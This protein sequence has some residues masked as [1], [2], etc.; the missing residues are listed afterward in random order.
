MIEIYKPLYCKKHSLMLKKFRPTRLG[1]PIAGSLIVAIALAFVIHPAWLL[2]LGATALYV[3]FAC[4]AISLDLDDKL[5]MI[6]ELAFLRRKRIE[7]HLPLNIRGVVE[8]RQALK[9]DDLKN[10]LMEYLDLLRDGG[11][12]SGAVESYL[13]KLHEVA[14]ANLRLEL[15]NGSTGIIDQDLLRSK[16]EVFRA[17]KEILE[18]N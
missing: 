11:Q 10:K 17:K 16:L 9:D 2:L 3:L 15:E 14:S 1:T 6:E 12:R 18:S 8:D 13:L 4:M 5:S 7:V